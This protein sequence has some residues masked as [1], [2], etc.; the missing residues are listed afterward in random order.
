[1]IRESGCDTCTAHFRGA[2]KVKVI[3]AIDLHLRMPIIMHFV[4]LVV[5]LCKKN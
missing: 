2:L 3:L 1:M 4:G 5:N